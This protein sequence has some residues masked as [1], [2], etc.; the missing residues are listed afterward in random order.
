MAQHKPKIAQHKPK[1][2]EMSMA[3]GLDLTK[4]IAATDT[5]TRTLQDLSLLP[6][7]EQVNPSLNRKLLFNKATLH[8]I[9]QTSFLAPYVIWI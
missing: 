8:F 3:I 7:P 9:Y 2:T 4:P 1:C 6:K 5:A